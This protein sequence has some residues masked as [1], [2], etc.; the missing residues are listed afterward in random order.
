MLLRNQAIKSWFICPS[1]ITSAFALMGK[2]QK[3]TKWIFFCQNTVYCHIAT[4]QQIAAWFLQSCWLV[5]H[6]HA[7]VCLS[8]SCN[9]LGLALGCW[10]DHSAEEMMLRV[11]CCS[12]CIVACPMHWRT[13][14]LKDKNLSYNR[15]GQV[16][17]RPKSK[18]KVLD[19]GL[20]PKS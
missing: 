15:W 6:I 10:G 20:R 9:Q 17:L 7:V 1:H 18:T 4:L 12:C 5:T 3:Y 8:K 19:F 2:T 13:E 16:W 14:F 11:M